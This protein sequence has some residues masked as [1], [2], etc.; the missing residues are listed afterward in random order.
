MVTYTSASEYIM[1]KAGARA[2]IAAIDLIIDKLLEAS[3]KAAESDL[4]QEVWLNDGQS[5]YKT[6]YNGAQSIQRSIEAFQRTRHYYVNQLNGRR[7][8]LIDSKNFTG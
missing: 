2:K 6:I 1:S 7:V 5:Q 3:L 8:R 4:Y